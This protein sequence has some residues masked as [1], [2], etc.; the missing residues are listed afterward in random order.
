MELHAVNRQRLVAQAHDDVAGLGRDVEILGEALAVDDQRMIARRLEGRGHV[1]EHALVLVFDARQLAVH[2]LR[3]AHHLAAEHLTDRLVAEADAQQRHLLLGGGAD[4]I[5]ADAGLVRRAGA[6]REHDAG[7]LQRHGLVDRD[8]VVAMHDA[9]RAEI[10]QKVDE[11]VGEAVV[12]IDQE[13][14]GGILVDSGGLSS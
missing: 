7:G 3:R 2:R 10:A 1:L 11:V 14:H 6:G 4:E 9:L 8:L 5:H 12:I 13:N